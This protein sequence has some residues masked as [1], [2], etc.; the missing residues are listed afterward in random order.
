MIKGITFLKKS[1][2]VILVLLGVIIGVAIFWHGKKEPLNTQV[3][4]GPQ[5]MQIEA[6][7][8]VGL[9]IK[10][11]GGGKNSYWLLNFAKFTDLG[12]AGA[13][14][15]ID[16]EYIHDSKP[17]YHLTAAS[18]SVHWESQQLKLY[19]PVIVS[20]DQTKEISAAEMLWEPKTQHI[21]AKHQV[22]VRINDLNI[23]T[24]EL[25]ADIE[26]N[27]FIMKGLTT[28]TSKY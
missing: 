7:Q 28:A 21:S 11:P 8:L 20:V 9:N 13:L 12:A 4:E 16:G 19:S 10:L 15:T 1:W 26:L 6:D 27:Q 2:I 18:G 3:F 25:A 5:G 17:V 24:E 14:D 23:Q 22:A